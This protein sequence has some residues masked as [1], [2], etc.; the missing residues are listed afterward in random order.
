[1]S[2]IKK[3]SKGNIT[4]LNGNNMNIVDNEQ[5]LMLEIECS[6]IDNNNANIIANAAR[7]EIYW[8]TVAPVN[9][10]CFSKYSN[11]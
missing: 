11:R 3:I 8:N 6:N 7:N 10:N 4:I 1:M 9:W 5:D 2:K